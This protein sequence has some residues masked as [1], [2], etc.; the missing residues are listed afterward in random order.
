MKIHRRAIAALLTVLAAGALAGQAP[1][2][3]Q[4]TTIE[5]FAKKDWKWENWNDRDPLICIMLP[6]GKTECFSFFRKPGGLMAVYGP[7][8]KDND[9]NGKCSEYLVSPPATVDATF[10]TYSHSI[11]DVQLETIRNVGTSWNVKRFVLGRCECSAFANQV[12]RAAGL[13]APSS[14]STKTPADYVTQL[15]TLNPSH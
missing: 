1:P 10:V 8:C 7:G 12:A 4:Q 9:L 3:A 15:K 6:D 11:T 13:K 2:A 5:F 14:T